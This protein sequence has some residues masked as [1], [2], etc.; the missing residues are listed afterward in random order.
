MVTTRL[1]T[2]LAIPLR[3]F[4]SG[5][6]RLCSQRRRR[7][8]AYVTRLILEL[9]GSRDRNKLSRPRV[10][11]S[12]RHDDRIDSTA[13][14]LD[15]FKQGGRAP[16]IFGYYRMLADEPRRDRVTRERWVRLFSR[17]LRPLARA[18]GSWQAAAPPSSTAAWSRQAWP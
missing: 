12:G 18:R 5:T 14:M 7:F 13:Q 9:I 2:A 15:W 8:K 11:E 6:N 17:S 1:V 3:V 16:R 10:P 4:V